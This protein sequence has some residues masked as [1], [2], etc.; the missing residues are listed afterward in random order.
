MERLTAEQLRK[1]QEN[2]LSAQKLHYGFLAKILFV[3]MDLIY[4][5]GR[6]LSKFKV[7]EVIARV[8]YQAWE[9]VAYIAITH[10]YKKAD[11]ARRIFD[12]VQES[13]IQQDNE[14][15]HLLI[16]EEWVHRLQI[17]ENFLLYRIIPQIIAFFYYHVCWFLYVIRPSMS[18]ALNAQFEDHAEHEYMRYV[19][20]HPELESEPFESAFKS[21][22][23]DFKSMADAVR[24]IGYDE[25]VHKE[26]SLSRI[27]DARFS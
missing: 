27:R 26:E 10:T 22:F 18:Y 14:Q 9:H 25:R 2:T 3:V 11:F 24:Q 20:E 23:G 8:P 19:Q 12:R 7:L 5:K 4:G 21:D 15:W 17:R 13:R 16:L 6:S 1:E